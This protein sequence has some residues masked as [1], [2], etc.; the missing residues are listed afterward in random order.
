VTNAQLDACARL[1]CAAVTTHDAYERPPRPLRREEAGVTRRGLLGLRLTSRARADVDYDG[2]TARVHAAFDRDGH[3]PLLRA[4]EPVGEVLADIAAPAPG[5]RVLDVGAGDG[6]VALACARRG[7]KVTA[8]DLAAAMVRSGRARCADVSWDRADVEE[9]P[10]P[11]GVFDVVTSA[12]GATLAARPGRAV[13]ELARVLRPGGRL[14]LTAWIARGL[15]GALFGVLDGVAP[16]PQGV[17]PASDWGDEAIARRRLEPTFAEVESRMRT[18]RLAFDSPG[19]MFDALVRGLPADEA[20]W[21]ALRP[22][23]DR[24]LAASNN[25]PPAAEV[26][27]RYRVYVAARPA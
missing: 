18:V 10:Y 21:P 6:N 2:A 9:L 7:A 27:A 3:E 19:A 13:G 15:P 23:F 4:I 8:C 17:R 26:D 5:T 25:R 22:G 1:R 24:L 16:M 20:Q 14:V 12:F 11:D